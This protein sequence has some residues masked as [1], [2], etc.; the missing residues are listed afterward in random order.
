[1]FIQ[2]KILELFFPFKKK[3]TYFFYMW[4]TFFFPTVRSPFPAGARLGHLPRAAPRCL[5]VL[6]TLAKAYQPSTGRDQEACPSDPAQAAEPGLQ[7]MFIKPYK[8][9]IE[10]NILFSKKI[11]YKKEGEVYPLDMRS[12]SIVQGMVKKI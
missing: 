12:R 6:Q 3:I 1:M 7:G 2:K 9:L 4:F 5:R 11:K 8:F 10:K